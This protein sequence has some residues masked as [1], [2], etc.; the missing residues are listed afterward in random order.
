MDKVYLN[1]YLSQGGNGIDDIG[2]LYH[3]SPR[4]Q[5]GR[6]GIGSFFSGIYR[7]LKPLIH[8]GLKALKKQSIK[9]S[10]SIINELGT[11]PIREILVQEG[12]TAVDE[13]AQKGL[14]KIRKIQDGDGTAHSFNFKSSRTIKRKLPVLQNQSRLPVKKKR[15]INRKKRK[16]QYSDIFTE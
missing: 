11:K 15:I 7:H 1:Y 12:K 5:K 8:S 6:G 13:L 4:Y 16:N 9:T 14:K 2:S 10:A 3:V